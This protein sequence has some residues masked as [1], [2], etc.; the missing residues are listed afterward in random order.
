MIILLI[1]LRMPIALHLFTLPAARLCKC[2]SVFFNS[3]FH[4]H[5]RDRYLSSTTGLMIRIEPG[6]VQQNS[7]FR[8]IHNFEFELM[9]YVRTK[10]L[11]WNIRLLAAQVDVRHRLSGGNGQIR[12]I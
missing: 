12:I 8:M 3:L 9:K 7:K 11:S 4:D 10:G 1:P 6:D 5:E 2:Y